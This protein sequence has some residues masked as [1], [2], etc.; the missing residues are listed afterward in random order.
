MPPD[1]LAALR[2]ETVGMFYHGYDNYMEHAFPE[3]EV[4]RSPSRSFWDMANQETVRI[5]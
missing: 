3:D 4:R 1:R 5:F 2:K